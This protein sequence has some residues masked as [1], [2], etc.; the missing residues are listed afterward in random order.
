MN[1]YMRFKSKIFYITYLLSITLFIYP[2]FTYRDIVDNWYTLHVSFDALS[3]L[4]VSSKSWCTQNALRHS[5]II[6]V[7]NATKRNLFCIRYDIN[8]LL[9]SGHRNIKI[10][11]I[12][13]ISCINYH[14]I[15]FQSFSQNRSRR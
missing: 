6:L 12:Y 10:S 9:C 15:K 8:I 3:I 14:T 13:F 2:Y 5:F 1:A 11:H 4:S 7:L